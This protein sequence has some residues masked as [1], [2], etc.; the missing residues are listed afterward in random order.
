MVLLFITIL[1]SI[2]SDQL[3]E[4]PYLQG[5]F[6]PIP[7][8]T[9][10]IV[11]RNVK[12]SRLLCCVLDCYERVNETITLHTFPRNQALRR[13]WKSRIKFCKPIKRWHRVCSRHFT[14]AD[15]RKSNL[16]TLLINIYKLL[17]ILNIFCRFKIQTTFLEDFCS[18]I[19]E[20]AKAT[21]C[22]TYKHVGPEAS[23]KNGRT[24]RKT[25][26]SRKTESS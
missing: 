23:G 21:N 15:Y 24:Q 5:F 8:Y 20:S 11:L 1:N 16:R 19:A 22:C 13:L 10:Q 14:D 25:D 9:G 4:K 2:M 18:S 17:K 3:H 26:Q 6:N 7:D 12:Q